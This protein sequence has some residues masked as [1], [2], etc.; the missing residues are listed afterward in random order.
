MENE[1]IKNAFKRVK[2]DIDSLYLWILEIKKEIEMLKKEIFKIKRT[3]LILE[4]IQHKSNTNPTHEKPI[5]KFEGIK[6]YFQSSTGN[7]G[8]PTLLRHSYAPT[9][10]NSTQLTELFDNKIEETLEKYKSEFYKK[11]KNLTNKEFEIFSLIYVLQE[12]TEV[13][14]KLLA[15]KTNLAPSSVRDLVNRLILKGI[16]IQKIKKLNREI[17][18][19]IPDELKKISDLEALS[20]L[21]NYYK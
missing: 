11:F 12:Q 15:E 14:Y 4:K 3:F 18:L 20:K 21:V 7:E 6:P 13:T 9:T 8:V 19:K 17:I 5:E 16:P 10:S 1:Q 2:E